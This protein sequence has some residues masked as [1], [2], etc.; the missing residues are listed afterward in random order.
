MLELS[1]NYTGRTM[2]IKEKLIR[3]TPQNRLIPG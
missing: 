1:G 2:H 3:A